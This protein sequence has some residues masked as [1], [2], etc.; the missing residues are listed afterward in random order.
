MKNKRMVDSTECMQYLERPSFA[1]FISAV[2]DSPDLPHNFVIL[3]AVHIWGSERTPGLLRA[4]LHR[5]IQMQRSAD[6]DNG[7]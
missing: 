5:E 1:I 3:T 4:D 6:T 7:D 2:Y